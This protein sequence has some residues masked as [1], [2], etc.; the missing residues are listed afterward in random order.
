MD[1]RTVDPATRVRVAVLG[2]GLVAEAMMEA[3][4]A[5]GLQSSEDVRAIAPVS[6]H[7]PESERAVAVSCEPDNRSMCV[8]TSVGS[9]IAEHVVLANDRVWADS[10]VPS[11]YWISRD[12]LLTEAT[13]ENTPRRANLHAVTRHGQKVRKGDLAAE[14]TRLAHAI[15]ADLRR[16]E[17]P[18]AV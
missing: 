4:R 11:T 8:T 7:N 14:V 17:V 10:A 18:A 13:M 9:V 3:L 6:N 5:A 2:E 15:A 1:D 16:N 12:S